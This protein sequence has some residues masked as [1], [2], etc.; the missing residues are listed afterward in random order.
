[1]TKKM[2]EQER[3]AEDR[4][5]LATSKKMLTFILIYL[6]LFIGGIIFLLRL[7]SQN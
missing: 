2:T 7:C 5:H 1:M 6:I 4:E 3:L